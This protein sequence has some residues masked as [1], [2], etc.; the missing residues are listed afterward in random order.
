MPPSNRN[1]CKASTDLLHPKLT[2]RAC[3]HCPIRQ[4]VPAR[5]VQLIAP[6]AHPIIH[7][8]MT[9]SLSGLDGKSVLY[10]YPGLKLCFSCRLF[11]P[12]KLRLRS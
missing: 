12:L 1:Q 10:S 8:V 2:T 11:S 9:R 7:L 4:P 5:H 6:H 3:G